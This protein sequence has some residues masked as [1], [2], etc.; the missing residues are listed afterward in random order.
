MKKCDS[1]IV[2]CQELPVA[3]VARL[4]PGLQLAPHSLT[5]AYK[6]RFPTNAR[7][8]HDIMNFFERRKVVVKLAFENNVTRKFYCIEVRENNTD[9]TKLKVTHKTQKIS[10]ENGNILNLKTKKDV[11]KLHIH[12]VFYISIIAPSRDH[13]W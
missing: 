12:A 10:F 5:E 4:S 13:Q 1:A 7:G 9:G 2:K 6:Y 8:S 11:Q 3:S